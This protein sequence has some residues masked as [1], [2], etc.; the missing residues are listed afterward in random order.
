MEW[1][2]ERERGGVGRE[3]TGRGGRQ[4]ERERCGGGDEVKGEGRER[5]M[6]GGR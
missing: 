5:E 6:G 1:A 2:G 3:I 4:R